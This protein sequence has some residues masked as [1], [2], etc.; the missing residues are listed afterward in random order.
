[1]TNKSFRCEPCVRHIMLTIATLLLFG[2]I[3][4][5]V[6]AAQE[7][8]ASTSS[9]QLKG[10]LLPGGAGAVFKGIPFAQPPVGPLRWR[11]PQ[12]VKAWQG[13]REALEPGA[14]CAQS[15]S[16]WN[17]QEAAASSEDCLYLNVWTPKWPAPSRLPVMV[18]IHGGGNTGGAGTADPLYDGTRLISHG[19]VLVVMD[20][21]LGI[22]G[23]L[24]HPELTRESPDHSSGNYAFLDQ[25]A[26][27]RWVRDNIA[28]FG[29]DPQNVTVFGQS[30][31]SMDLGVLMT[32]PLAKGLFHRAIGE[33]G[34]AGSMMSQADA[35]RAG[36]QAAEQLKAPAQGSLAYLRSLSMADLLKVRRVPA[37]G[38]VDNWV[39]PA[40][41][42]AVF[43]AG[44]AHPVPLLI[45]SN[46]IEFPGEGTLDQ[47][48][49]GI[50]RTYRDRAPRLL[51]L[52][53]LK[54]PGDKG[55]V[56]PLYGGPGDQIATDVQFRCP[57][58]HQGEVHSAAGNPVWE[59]Q[60]DRAIPPKP[61]VIHSSELP[62]VFGN[63]WSTGSQGGNYQEA[64]R[65]LSD[66]IQVYWTNFARTGDPNGPG[67]PRWPRFT[68]QSRDYMQF[69][70]T[71]GVV[72][73]Q[74]QRR[75]F[76]EAYNEPPVKLAKCSASGSGQ[77]CAK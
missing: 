31:G 23:F 32:S 14:P 69:T 59:Y 57:G 50:Q 63:L 46:A 43:E 72:A 62:Y 65:K 22:F 38:N 53:G 29:G 37:G 2:V 30:A 5:A 27:L 26:A 60:F 8:V 33:S 58:I 40:N 1:M 64:D 55:V 11:E 39:F 34:A 15:P 44:K 28:Q 9:G 76:C 47:L 68:A 25:I 42:V 48:R 17:N 3:T 75:A 35:E 70:L 45:G 61:T 54:S 77:D 20:Y 13:V 51:E 4:S 6:A 19:V 41:P 66:A 71:G 10:R 67:V 74:N 52:Y 24:A 16:G 73:N 18:W 56:D 36:R 7:P 12:P 49:A 21:R